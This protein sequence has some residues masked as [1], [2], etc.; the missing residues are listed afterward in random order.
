MPDIDGC[1]VGGASLLADKWA[2]I[3]NYEEVIPITF[4][5]I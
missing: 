4:D 5:L 1:L 3:M 2:R